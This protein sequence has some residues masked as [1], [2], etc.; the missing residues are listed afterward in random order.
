MSP[1]IIGFV[2]LIGI[3]VAIVLSIRIKP[4]Q[5]LSCPHCQIEFRSDLFLF[6][7]NALHYQEDLYYMEIEPFRF[8]MLAYISY[9]KSEKAKNDSDGASAFLRL[10]EYMLKEDPKYLE[11]IIEE[12]YSVCMNVSENQKY[13]DADLSIYGNFKDIFDN[14]RALKRENFG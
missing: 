10:V 11:P 9:I 6:Q 1:T 13:Y 2:V 3:I 12:V 5:S 8:Y 14:I 4:N 7:E